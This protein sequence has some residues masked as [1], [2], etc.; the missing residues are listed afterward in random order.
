MVDEDEVKEKVDIVTLRRTTRLSIV[1]YKMT[2][3]PH[4]EKLAIHL[5]L[6]S[7]NRTRMR[8]WPRGW[9]S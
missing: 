2:R 9:W 3:S 7:S 6:V 8:L 1:H 4:M 5:S